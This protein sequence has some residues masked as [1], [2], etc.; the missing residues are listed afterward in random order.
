MGLKIALD[1]FGTGYS[2]LS[3]LS[4]YPSTSSRSTEASFGPGAG[5]IRQRDRKHH[6]RTRNGSACGW[7]RK[8]WRRWSRPAIC[9][10]PAATNCRVTCWTTGAGAERDTCNPRNHRHRVDPIARLSAHR[11]KRQASLVHDRLS[12]LQRTGTDTA[13]AQAS[14]ARHR[15]RRSSIN[16]AALASSATLVLAEA[17]A[18]S[19]ASGP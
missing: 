1:D 12:S 14:A 11:E 16:Q 5:R 13:R 8:G 18:F 10:L 2:S 19:A 6:H 7:W 17:T 4:R 15:A 3:Y 9:A